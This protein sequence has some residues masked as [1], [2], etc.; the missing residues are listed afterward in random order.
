LKH[1]C[2]LGTLFVLA[3]CTPEKHREAETVLNCD[4]PELC[5]QKQRSV[6]QRSVPQRKEWKTTIAKCG[7]KPGFKKDCD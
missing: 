1:L 3:G 6:P 4:G 5:K 7:D 2:L